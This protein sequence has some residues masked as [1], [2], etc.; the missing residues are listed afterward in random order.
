MQTIKNSARLRLAACAATLLLLVGCKPSGPKALLEG[1]RLIREERPEDAI[2]PLLA[3]TQLMPQNAQAWNHLGLAYHGSGQFAEA[4][5]AYKK[6]IAIHPNLAAARFNIGCLHFESGRAKA[7]VNDLATFNVLQTNS[8]EGWLW[9]GTAQLRAGQLVDAEKSLARA[10]QINPLAPEAHN[11]LGVLQIQQKRVTDGVKSL[12]A[13]LSHTNY[14][15]TLLNAAISL[16]HHY[17]GRAADNR[18]E[19]LLRYR[20]YLETAANPPHAADVRTAVKQLETETELEPPKVASTNVSPRIVLNPPAA[21]L[22][23]R[24]VSATNA[25]AITNLVRNVGST[26][27]VT[28][29]KVTNA[30]PRETNSLTTTPPFPKPPP[31]VTPVTPPELATNAPPGTATNRAVTNVA[32]I[33]PKPKPALP[34]VPRYKY[35]KPAAPAEGRREAAA[36]PFEKALTSHRIGQLPEA[37]AG[38][39]AAVKADPAYFQAQLNLAL[40]LHGAGDLANALLTYETALAIDP[41]SLLARYNFALAL[42]KQLF[43]LDSA[44]EL[45]ELLGTLPAYVPAHLQAANLY[46]QQLHQPE[47]ARNHYRRVLQ[48]D[49]GHSEASNIRRWLAAHPE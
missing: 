31:E 27:G 4:L 13:V 8:Y 3:A 37:I 35:K 19:A 29:P 23:N 44:N 45:E 40:A 20:K 39:S 15:P 14:P 38:Y 17:P 42:D 18:K 48:L 10:S 9:L 7:A 32:S 6:A 47:L 34:N 21:S 22:T 41:L 11:T 5:E 30:P 46:A 26:N 28:A 16:H 43:P 49:P 36:A 25:P 12:S 2:E 1:E 24:G 33:P